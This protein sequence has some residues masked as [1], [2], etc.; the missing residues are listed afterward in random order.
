MCKIL[1]LIITVH[2]CLGKF[3][4]GSLSPMKKTIIKSSLHTLKHTPLLLAWA[5]EEKAPYHMAAKVS[6]ES[7]RG[8]VSRLANTKDGYFRKSDVTNLL[9]PAMKEFFLKISENNFNLENVVRTVNYLEDS[10]KSNVKKSFV[11]SENLG[12][13]EKEVSS[14]KDHEQQDLQEDNQNFFNTYFYNYLNMILLGLFA[15]TLVIGG[16]CL[17]I[18]L[19]K[20][21]F[22][23][24]LVLRAAG[25]DGLELNRLLV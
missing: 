18:T 16:I 9:Q 20:V 21:F 25:F 13:I 10:L 17:A 8:F 2:S 11:N 15:V 5:Q 1:L 6:M 3:K 22:G 23:L 24:N 7:L 19:K 14:L 4:P 12:K